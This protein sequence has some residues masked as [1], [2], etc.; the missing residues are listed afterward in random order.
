MR[1]TWPSQARLRASR[2]LEEVLVLDLLEVRMIQ[3]GLGRDT[4]AGLVDQHLG[5]EVHGQ[6]VDV[7]QDII[8]R[9]GLPHGKVRLVVRQAGNTGPCLLVG[10]AESAASRQGKVRSGQ[11]LDFENE[12]IGVNI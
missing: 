6:G 5:Q 8:E 11:V 2:L 7:G 12:K 3:S 10:C 9:V 4:A 1:R